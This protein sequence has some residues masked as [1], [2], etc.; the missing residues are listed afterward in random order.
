MP[1]YPAIFSKSGKLL[2]RARPEFTGEDFSTGILI[3][4]FDEHGDALNVKQKSVHGAIAGNNFFKQSTDS[5][6]SG[7]CYGFNIE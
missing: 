3:A 5:S 4:T 7:S 1:K 6:F 2:V